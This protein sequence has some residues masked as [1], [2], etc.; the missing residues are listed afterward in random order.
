MFNGTA[1][2]AYVKRRYDPKAIY[3]ELLSVEDKIFSDIRRETDGSGENYSWLTDADDDFNGS[4]DFVT[5]QNASN[6]NNNAV[7][8]KFLSDWNDTSAVAAITSSIIGKTRNNDGA[9]MKAVDVAM[10]KRI[11]ALAHLFA[12]Q[13]Q[14]SGWGEVSQIT[15]VGA[16]TFSP[17]IPSD[18]TK[19]VKGMALHFSS[20]LNG[21]VLRSATVLYVTGVSY[22]EGA[23]LVT[24]S[25]TRASVGAV[26]DDFAFIAGARQDSA[27]PAR[28]VMTGLNS[29]FPNQN[30]AIDAND[31]T[32]FTVNRTTNSRLYGT[33]INGTTGGSPIGALIDGAQEAITMGNA[34]KLRCYCSK[35]TYRSIAKDLQ[36]A[37]QYHDNP[38]SKTVGTRRLTFLSDGDAEATL[39][40]SRTTNDN[41]IWG[42]DPSQIIMRSIGGAPHIETEDGLTMARQAS[43]AAWE[44]RWFAQS[45]YEFINSPGGLRVQLV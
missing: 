12:I 8:S 32:L 30:V 38:G 29:W 36:T 39:E 19:Y 20:S 42:F 11:K 7:G 43:A 3:N 10:R 16:S 1:L 37:V 34:K 5:A 28:I 9:W 14:G 15:A 4:P 44:I 23:E 31:S 6:N 18:I 41:Q 26:S 2:N 27:T 45:V 17:K 22:T 25:G 35:A 21:A 40:V 13:L 24:L 33:F